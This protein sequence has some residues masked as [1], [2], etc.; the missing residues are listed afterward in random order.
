M[1]YC[2]CLGGLQAID[3]SSAS[4]AIGDQSQGP[5][6]RMRRAFV[7]STSRR[8]P[9]DDRERSERPDAAPREAFERLLPRAHEIVIGAKGGSCGLTSEAT[10][11]TRQKSI[12]CRRTAYPLS[13]GD[14]P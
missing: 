2:R 3:D 12:A 13:A 6:V 11:R 10:S 14:P 7:T 8:R 4:T 5:S 1:P 9:C